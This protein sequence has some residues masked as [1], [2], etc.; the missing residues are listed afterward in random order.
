[1]SAHN[2]LSELAT[3]LRFYPEQSPFGE[4]VFYVG[5]YGSDVASYRTI[6]EAVAAAAGTT[7]SIIKLAPGTHY[8]S[9][10]VNIL[11]GMQIVGSG[12]GV[13]TIQEVGS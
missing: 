3:A 5:A 9:S 13:T 6:S 10:K 8:I 2:I 4:P 1:M 12:S 11:A 7:R